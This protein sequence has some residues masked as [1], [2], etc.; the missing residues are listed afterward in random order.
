MALKFEQQHKVCHQPKIAAI[1]VNVDA[2]IV[3]VFLHES[4]LEKQS[5]AHILPRLSYSSINVML[6]MGHFVKFYLQ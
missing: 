4:L 1:N 6:N 2:S 3:V 5:L